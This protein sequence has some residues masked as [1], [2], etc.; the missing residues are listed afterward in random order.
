MRKFKVIKIIIVIVTLVALIAFITFNP[1]QHSDKLS[2][3]RSNNNEL[4]VLQEN[5]K[6]ER[7]LTSIGISLAGLSSY[8]LVSTFESKSKGQKL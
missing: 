4:P 1:N 8:I 5:K 7:N 2:S 6:R 3:H